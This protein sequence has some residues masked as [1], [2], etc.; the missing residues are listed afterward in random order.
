MSDPVIR[1]IAVQPLGTVALTC[2]LMRSQNFHLQP[3]ILQAAPGGLAAS[4]SMVTTFR[5]PERPAHQRYRIVL[6][7]GFNLAIF[8]RDPFAKY[9]VHFLGNRAPSWFPPIPVLAWKAPF[10][11]SISS[12]ILRN[13]GLFE[14]QLTSNGHFA[15]VDR[16]LWLFEINCTGNIEYPI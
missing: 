3:G 13:V 10:P 2:P 1:Q 7:H 4:P 5:H 11:S 9:A 15:S 14:I 16:F 12:C 6:S 8:H